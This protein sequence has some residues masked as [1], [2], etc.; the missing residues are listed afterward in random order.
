MRWQEEKSGQLGL[1][2]VMVVEMMILVIVVKM[3]ILVMVVKM[4][5]C[6]C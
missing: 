2:L 6:W 4:M 3:M 1:I 5:T